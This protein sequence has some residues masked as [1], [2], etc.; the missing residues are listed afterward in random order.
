MIAP[1]N[2]STPTF[3]TFV[4]TFLARAAYL[5]AASLCLDGAATS[6]RAETTAEIVSVRKIWDAGRHNAFTD[7]IRWHDRF[8]CTFREADDHVGGDGKLRVLVSTDGDAW[9]SAALVAEPG[10]DLR[11]PKLS[12]TPDDRLMI[13]AGGSVYEG[14]KTL[15]GRQ[16]RV[17]FSNDGRTW[18]AP[19]RV[20]NEGEW[21]WRVTWHKGV[22]YGAAYDASKRRTDAARAAAK[23]TTPAEPGPADWKLK[24][25]RSTDGV[26]DELVTHLDV[27]G[28]PNET[29]LRFAADDTLTALVRREGGS[30]HGWIGTSRPPYKEWTYHETGFR[31]G[32]P[33]FLD[34]P[35]HGRYAVA[36]R[37]DPKAHTVLF[38]M[39]ESTL[40]PLVAFPSG[41]DTSYAGLAWHDNLLWVS[42]YASHEGK[43]SIYLAKVRL[44]AK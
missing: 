6:A 10:I 21:L 27:P 29:T 40:T 2:R 38:A 39:T 9:T 32:G 37:Y 11:D 3:G 41:G 25:Y 1:S 28:H 17:A 43:T 20:L 24:L 14:T 44:G 18:T 7:L 22:C 12:I 42:Y 5:L 4:V 15:K 16:P 23:L 36:R 26:Q 31:V 8:W 35:G 33:N 30:T 34:V 13:V 19:Q